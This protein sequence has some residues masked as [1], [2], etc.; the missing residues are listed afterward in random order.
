MPQLKPEGIPFMNFKKFR[1][2]MFPDYN[3]SF[4]KIGLSGMLQKNAVLATE[5]L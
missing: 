1:N 3:T 4:S 2:L 5:Q